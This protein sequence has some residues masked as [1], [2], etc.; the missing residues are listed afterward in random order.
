MLDQEEA[1]RGSSES[2][3][4]LQNIHIPDTVSASASEDDLHTKRRASPTELAPGSAGMSDINMD[5]QG[6]R[7]NDK[8]KFK[9][10]DKD[11]NGIG[12]GNGDGEF[13]F[14]QGVNLVKRP[15]F[16]K[17]RSSAVEGISLAALQGLGSSR[18]GSPKK[19]S[20]GEK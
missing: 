5:G 6:D 10:K 16:K 18:H 7:E 17:Q 9:D 14:F 1:S 4:T 15:S 19:N 2:V 12:M 13:S 11:S 8:D 3:P 20:T